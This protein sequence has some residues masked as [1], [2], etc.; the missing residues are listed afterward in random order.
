MFDYFAR[1]GDGTL[2]DFS[3]CILGIVLLS[4]AHVLL[5]IDHLDYFDEHF[6]ARLAACA[7]NVLG[8]LDCLNGKFQTLCFFRKRL[9]LSAKR[10]RQ[11]DGIPAENVLNLFQRETDD[12]QRHDL[13]KPGHVARAIEPVPRAGVAARLEQIQSIVMMQGPHCD[14]RKFSEFTGLE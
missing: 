10:R 12:L 1:N 3:L 2:L 6:P 9:P 11:I 13:F 5:H 8:A 4:P 14:T 7:N